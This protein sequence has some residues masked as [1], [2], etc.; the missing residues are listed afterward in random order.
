MIENE[1]KSTEPEQIGIDA[2][3]ADYINYSRNN[4]DKSRN[5][6][7]NSRDK[8]KLSIVFFK[9]KRDKSNTWDISFIFLE[10]D[11]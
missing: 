4:Y 10:F 6:Y 3:V 5:N 2:P 1:I 7:A 9:D 8:T 11:S